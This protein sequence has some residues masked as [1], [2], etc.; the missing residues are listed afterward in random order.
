V[1]KCLNYLK[2]KT[3]PKVNPKVNTCLHHCIFVADYADLIIGFLLFFGMA[4]ALFKKE[5]VVEIFVIVHQAH[6]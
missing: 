3:Y 5:G 2:G 4:K 6:G 1:N